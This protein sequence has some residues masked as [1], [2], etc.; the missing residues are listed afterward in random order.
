MLFLAV[1]ALVLPAVFD[2]SVYGNLQHEGIRI[3]Q[4]SLWTSGVLILIYG[5]SFLFVLKT[6]RGLFTPPAAKDDGDG[7][8]MSKQR[9]LL[10]MAAATLLIAYLSEMLVGEID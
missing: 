9:A 7:V 8:V 4:L 3:E 2:L 5:V 6:H 10:S 1:A